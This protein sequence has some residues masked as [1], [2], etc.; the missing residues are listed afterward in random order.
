MDGQEM[1]RNLLNGND[2]KIIGVDLIGSYARLDLRNG[3]TIEFGRE[4]KGGIDWLVVK[5]NDE[6]VYQG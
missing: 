3:D 2:C 6:I 5:I 4:H 1:L